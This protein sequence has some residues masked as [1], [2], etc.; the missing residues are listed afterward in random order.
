MK[1][2]YPIKG[3]SLSMSDMCAINKYYEAACTAEYLLDTYDSVNEKNALALGY[4]VRR[5]MDKFGYE[6]AE[7][8]SEV[9]CKSGGI[10]L[11]ICDIEWDTDG[12]DGK[13][14]PDEVVH[15]FQGYNDVCDPGLED[16]VSKW[17]SDEYGHRAKEFDFVEGED[18]NLI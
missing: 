1:F 4:E 2:E 12:C 10:T 15:Q 5:L 3:I 16:D 14:L 18:D 17:L 7:A 6:E 13:E 8:I 9:V 11:C